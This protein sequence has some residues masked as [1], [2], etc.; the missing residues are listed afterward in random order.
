MQHKL[1]PMK[2]TLHM[3]RWL[4]LCWLIIV[5][6]LLGQCVHLSRNPDNYFFY[7]DEQRARWRFDEAHVALVCVCMLTEA[8]IT[9]AALL[10]SRPRALWLRCAL[11]L[12]LLTPFAAMSLPAV[13]H[14]PMHVI[15]HHGVL[16]VWLLALLVG[17]CGALW[18]RCFATK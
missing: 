7:N 1:H 2:N 8:V 15:F 10:S 14:M 18:L 13:I 9:G 6:L 3:R 17:F 11:A 12:A 16:L 4:I 5:L